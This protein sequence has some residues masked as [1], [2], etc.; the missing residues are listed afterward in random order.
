MS[1]FDRKEEYSWVGNQE[2][3]IDK[4]NI[5]KVG[6]SVIGRFGGNS[7]AGQHKNEDGCIV[8]VSDALQPFLNGKAHSF[9][10]GMKVK[11]NTECHW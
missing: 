7:S 4:I 5:Q 2:T 11:S 3:F 6:H 1:E 9:R 8:W 10:R